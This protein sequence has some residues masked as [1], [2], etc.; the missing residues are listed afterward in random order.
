MSKEIIEKI[1]QEISGFKSEIKTERVGKVFE[2]GDGVCRMWGL[3]S[4]MAQE[5][6][7]IET[8][9]GGVNGIALNLEE[10]S[11]GVVILGDFLK[12]KEGNIV[13]GTGRV[14]S[15]RVGKEM[16]GRVVNALGEGR[17]LLLKKMENFIRLKKSPP[18]LL[19]ASP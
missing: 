13:R 6:V 17:Y 4:V 5:M 9:G 8:D 11:V 15:V 14:L 1:K 19:R 10:D 16:V 3:S 18:A 7:E 12:V 2:V